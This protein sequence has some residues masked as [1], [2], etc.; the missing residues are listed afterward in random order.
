MKGRGALRTGIVLWMVMAVLSGGCS[1]KTYTTASVAETTEEA[2][3]TIEPETEPI[4]IEPE[5]EET[6]PEEPEERIEV[7][8]KIRSYLT[9]EMVDVD[10]ANRRPLAIMMSNDKESLPQ[11]GINRAGVVYEAP[12]EGDMNRYMAVIEIGRAHV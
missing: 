6:V 5:T 10:K 9:G 2:D 7:D 1:Q 3:I 12:V 8:G 4:T 11:Y